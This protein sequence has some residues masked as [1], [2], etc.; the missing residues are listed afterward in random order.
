MASAVAAALPGRHKHAEW[1]LVYSTS[2]SG[3][4]L[5]TMYRSGVKS[6]RTVLVV[7]D[8]CGH[9]FGAYCTEPLKVNPRYQGTGEAFVFQMHPHMIKYGWQQPAHGE[10]RND[11]FMLVAHDS[12][13]IG[14][15]PHFALWLDSDL[16]HGHTGTCATF[17]CPSLAG[18]EDFKVKAI[19]LWQVGA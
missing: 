13:G 5:Q 4:S 18:S 19:E 15:G 17:G 11:F 6:A 12:V 7:H 16:L 2:K 10:P 9:I 1:S 3:F 8:F 14:G